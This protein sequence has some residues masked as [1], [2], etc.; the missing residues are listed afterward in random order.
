MDLR[1]YF[2]K[3][4][5]IIT[6]LALYTSTLKKILKGFWRSH[7]IHVPS[8]EGSTAILQKRSNHSKDLNQTSLSS[9]IKLYQRSALCLGQRD[10]WTDILPL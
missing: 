5:D 1:W 3:F 6:F 9:K 8:L 10:T 7:V 2:D 4:V